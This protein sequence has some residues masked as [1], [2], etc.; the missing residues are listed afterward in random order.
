MILTASLCVGQMAS[1]AK[2][3]YKASGIEHRILEE[4]GIALSVGHTSIGFERAQR[5]VRLVE[6]RCTRRT[7]RLR[8]RRA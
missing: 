5:L 3:D 7:H 6:P 8:D 1:A 2:Y 4:T